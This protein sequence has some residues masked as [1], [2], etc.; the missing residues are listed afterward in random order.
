MT[1]SAHLL[2]LFFSF[3]LTL[4]AAQTPSSPPPPPPPSDD[5][6]GIFISYTFSG[7]TRIH[8]YLPKNS[9][10]QPYTF[11]ASASVINNDD[12]PLRSWG[13]SVGFN[14]R[15]VLVSADPAVLSDGSTFPVRV[16]PTNA[17]FSGFPEADLETAID[18]AGDATKTQVQINIKGTLFG[19]PQPTIPLPATLSLAND[20][21]IC[22]KATVIGNATLQSCCTRDPKFKSNSTDDSTNFLPRQDGDL[23]IAYDVIQSSQSNYLASVQIENQNPLGRLDYWKL[24][25]EWMRGEFIFSMKGAHTTLEDQQTCIFGEQGQFYQALDFSTV[26]NCERSPTIVDLPLNLANDSKV[27]LIPNCCR[28]GTVLPRVMDPKQSA[29]AF[30]MQVFKM[31]PDLNRTK[32]F[33]PQNWKIVGSGLNPAYLCGQPVRVSPA[34]FPDPSGL[35]SN[36]TA[37]ASWQVVCNITRPAGYR[38]KCCVSFSAFYNDSVVPC[39]TCA[40][41]CPNARPMCSSTASA[42]L[43]PPEAVLVPFENRTAKA[44]S[45]AQLKHHDVPSPLPCGDNCGVSLNWHVLTDYR[46]G[47]SARMTLFNWGDTNIADW[48]A[49]VGLE[50]VFEGYENTYSFNATVMPDENRTIFI[51]GMPGQNY[52]TAEVDGADPKRDPRVPGKQQSVISFTKKLTP[53][54]DISAGDGFPS[55]VYFNGEECAMPTMIPTSG[56]SRMTVIGGVWGSLVALLGVMVVVLMEL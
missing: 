1:P 4:S 40:C 44:L 17:T 22:P 34:L 6:N 37:V 53:G 25:W 33:P 35:P 51:W 41:G 7:R 8:P 11:T 49:A 14:H 23:T 52:L 20:G 9:P 12:V 29:S 46:N 30:Q 13:L 19:S 15:E 32:L 27:G 18:T 56:G 21:Y 16:G 10:D 24:S 3:S 31:P 50:K 42:L 38:P 5:C 39:R 55:K 43:L 47:W 54:I 26:M 48:F 36:S 2:L 45:W 28:N